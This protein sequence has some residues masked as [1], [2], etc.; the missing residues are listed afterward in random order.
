MKNTLAF[1][2][3][4]KG[5][6]VIL[7]CCRHKLVCLHLTDTSFCDYECDNIRIGEEHM[8]EETRS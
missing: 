3:K 1:Y 4:L 8:T 5:A 7:K 6:F 2:A